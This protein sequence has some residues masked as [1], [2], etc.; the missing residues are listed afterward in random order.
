[1][2]INEIDK[3]IQEELNKYYEDKNVTGI[4]KNKELNNMVNRRWNT[5]NISKKE[6]LNGLGFMYSTDDFGE[7]VGEENVESYLNKLYPEKIIFA[8]RRKL[9]C[10]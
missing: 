10:N 2:F 8:K 7:K 1:M 5:L 9:S 4:Y 3:Q 6:Y